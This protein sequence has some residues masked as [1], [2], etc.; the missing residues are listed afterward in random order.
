[1]PPPSLF[2]SAHRSLQPHPQSGQTAE[3]LHGAGAPLWKQRRR[4][5]AQRGSGTEFKS[6]HRAGRSAALE[7]SGPLDGGR[8]LT[9]QLVDASFNVENG[10]PIDPA[11]EAIP[12]AWQPRK[13]FTQDSA[14]LL[15]SLAKER[16][17]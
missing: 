3:F 6:C 17:V 15:G 2:A 12:G 7:A 10:L 13:L 5:T 1:M 11:E 4:H 8:Y 9:G 16:R 14:E